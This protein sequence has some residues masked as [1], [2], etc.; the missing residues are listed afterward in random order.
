[1]NY[2]RKIIKVPD[3]PTLQNDI[4]QVETTTGTKRESTTDISNLVEKRVKKMQDLAQ[5]FANLKEEMQ[6]EESGLPL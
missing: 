5:Q 4:K 6:T 1:M 3:T 2:A